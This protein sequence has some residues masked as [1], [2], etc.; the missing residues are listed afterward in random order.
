MVRLKIRNRTWTGSVQGAVATWSVISYQ[1]ATAPCTDPIQV[2][3][4]L[5]RQGL[6]GQLLHDLHV[7]FEDSGGLFRIGS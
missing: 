1:V 4:L 7:G 5:S 3:I 2:R 6:T